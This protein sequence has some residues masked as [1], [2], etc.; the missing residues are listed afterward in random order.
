MYVCKYVCICEDVSASV[1][2]YIQCVSTVHS[3]SHSFH[4]LLSHLMPF[5]LL[6]WVNHIDKS[7]NTYTHI[8]IQ[9]KVISAFDQMKN[10]IEIYFGT[11][12]MY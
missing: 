1:S 11:L 10:V 6:P 8:G 5:W 3:T 9:K 12:I 7:A 2:V 4:E